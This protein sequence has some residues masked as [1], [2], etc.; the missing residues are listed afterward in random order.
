MKLY[1]FAVI[2]N[3]KSKRKDED[4]PKPSIIVPI[5]NV[6]AENEQAAMLLAARAIPNEY[7]DKIAE[8]DVA[9]RPF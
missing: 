5:T 2:Y 6:L 8:C 4:A 9:V 7:A 1:Q 3:P